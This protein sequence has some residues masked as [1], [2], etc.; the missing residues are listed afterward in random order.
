[1][2]HSWLQ[3][4][5]KGEL[6]ELAQK[7]R[8]ADADGLLKDDLVDLLSAHL[9]AHETTYAKNPEFRDYYSR[10]GSP[11]KRDRSSPS[12]AATL[13]RSRRRTLVREP[14][15][16]PVAMEKKRAGNPYAACHLSPRVAGAER[17]R[18]PGVSVPACRGGRPIHPDDADQGES[19]V[20]T[21]TH[22]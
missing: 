5:R 17:S 16:E 18:Y 13:T 12:D 14:S 19:V 22:R 21:V 3:R 2:S 6:L 1:M 4:K 20:G 8:L 10:A 7:S 11:L 15:E 9:N